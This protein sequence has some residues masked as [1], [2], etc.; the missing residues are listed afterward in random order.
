VNPSP[1]PS[2]Q[3][4][5]AWRSAAER[6]SHWAWDK[7]I[8][9]TD[10][11]GGYHSIADR[12][13]IMKDGNPLGATTTRPPVKSRGKVVLDRS[14]LQRHFLAT[15]PQQIVGLHS[16]SP[17][18]TSRWGGFDIDW[19]GPLST[20][21]GI[22][23]AAAL[24]WYARL[25]GFGLKP[26]LY[27]SNGKGGFHL[28][29][30]FSSPLATADVFAFCKWLVADHAFF[31]MTAPPEHFPK[32]V[33]I[34]QGRYGNWQRLP[35][36]HH[37][38]AYWSEV[39]DGNRWATG[40]DAVEHVLSINGDDAG[41]LPWDAIRCLKTAKTAQ[42][43]QQPKPGPS[44]FVM[45]AAGD[46]L[47]AR[48]LAYMAR[49]PNLSEGQGRDKV[50]YS[51]AAFLVRDLALPD[52]DALNYLEQWD[53]GN[54]PPKGRDRLAVIIANAHQYGERA[55]GSGLGD[56]NGYH[57]RPKKK[58]STSKAKPKPPTTQEPNLGSVPG[59][60]PNTESPPG[61]VGEEG[62]DGEQDGPTGYDI[63]KVYFLEF[64][65]PVFRRADAIH[66]PPLGRVVR[67]S[68]ACGQAGIELIDRLMSASDAP[69]DEETMEVD[70]QAIPRFFRLWAPFAW[71]DILRSLPEEEN[72][73]EIVEPAR[74]EFRARMSA[75]FHSLVSFGE[76][77]H[78]D[79]Q[80]T[81]TDTCVERRTVF[82]W[83][84]LWARPG[85]WERIRSLAVW[86]KKRDG[87]P[88]P[89]IALRVELFSQIRVMGF[90][91]MT[92]N[93]FS[94]LAEAYDFGVDK[95]DNRVCGQRAVLL[96]PEFVAGLA[97]Q[98]SEDNDEPSDQVGEVSS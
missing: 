54:S 62:Q 32:Q 55:Y 78:D 49:L 92:Q 90:A 11:W 64:Y 34:A 94:K 53:Q 75:A 44:I 21:P 39:W 15:M 50:A 91:D 9:R 88:H 3:I 74:E 51:F 35:G 10:V 33:G 70:R 2:D 57:G 27:Q 76:V 82:D 36:R 22:N 20:A 46:S 47:E 58:A 7:L 77:I 84:V 87:E 73:T 30:I 43:T 29:Q 4:I 79:S 1:I 71:A 31:E 86:T 28:W 48:I 97:A 17:D 85:K 72:S 18:N 25:E 98:P 6:L 59:T 19:H 93:K 37:T 61:P 52:S 26:L 14:L 8:N 83:C 41:L 60:A 68:E 95:T 38:R 56:A 24:G 96:T 13:K 67:R 45:Q 40:E 65:Q 89:S 69:L 16:T 66:S 23:E 80:G 42:Q 81:G 5:A 12:K 63:T